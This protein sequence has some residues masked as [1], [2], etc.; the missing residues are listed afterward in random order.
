MPK[1]IYLFYLLM[2]LFFSFSF[3]SCFA[4]TDYDYVTDF[5]GKIPKNTKEIIAWDSYITDKGDTITKGVKY[6]EY[7]ERGNM[8][9]WEYPELHCRISNEYDLQNRV[10][11]TDYYCDE[12]SNNGITFYSYPSKNVV[13]KQMNVTGW[14]SLGRTEYQYNNKGKIIRMEWKDSIYEQAYNPYDVEYEI[15]HTV[16]VYK[17][18]KKDNLIE[19]N[20]FD[21]PNLTTLQTTKYTYN[22]YNQVTRE[23]TNTKQNDGHFDILVTKYNYYAYLEEGETKPKIFIINT[24]EISDYSTESFIKEYNYYQKNVIE[25]ETTETHT[26][27]DETDKGNYQLI[28]KNER[29]IRKKYFSTP[30]NKKNK[31]ITGWTDYQYIFY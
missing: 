10:I 9:F 18:D 8:I 17:Y 1:S 6:W 20:T 4:Q 27:H 7:D 24:T 30:K 28:Y 29:L 13:L 15:N 26:Y 22:K 16:T 5:I 11:S 12:S 3:C 23:E 14:I 25:V 21:L 2:I 19:R 31:K